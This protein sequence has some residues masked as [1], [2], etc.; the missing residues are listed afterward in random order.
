MREFRTYG[1]V[2]G[3][4]SNGRP[5]RDPEGQFV[6]SG[7]HSADAALTIRRLA[8]RSREALFE[9][10]GYA[11]NQISPAECTTYLAHGP[12]PLS[13][14]ATYRSKPQFP[15]RCRARLVAIGWPVFPW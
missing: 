3:A 5:Y 12:G 1:S 11:L 8:P 14:I 9:V 15:A 4:P 7:L 13:D 2:R 6:T 10:I